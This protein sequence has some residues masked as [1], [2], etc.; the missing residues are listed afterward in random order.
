M[1]T[2]PSVG[3][4]VMRDPLQGPSQRPVRRGPPSHAF[5][6]STPAQ[7]VDQL[8][9]R[10]LCLRHTNRIEHETRVLL[11]GLGRSQ[12]V[13]DQSRLGERERAIS[14]LL[15]RKPAQATCLPFSRRTAHPSSTLSASPRSCASIGSP[16]IGESDLAPC[17]LMDTK[18]SESVACPRA[19]LMQIVEFR[20]RRE[21]A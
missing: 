8:E 14:T 3:S 1:A 18:G 17:I 5:S 7:L 13:H 15:H 9:R 16:R 4:I 10:S 20:T 11:L 19:F 6:R 2:S 21:A 12:V